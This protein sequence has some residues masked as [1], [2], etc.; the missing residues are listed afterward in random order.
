MEWMTSVGE[1]IGGINCLLENLGFN[2]DNLWNVE[3]WV[4]G[5]FA[6][7][8]FLGPLRQFVRQI[9][10]THYSELDKIYMDILEMSLDR[11]Y[12]RDKE[13]IERFVEYLKNQVDPDSQQISTNLAPVRQPGYEGFRQKTAKE[14][15]RE[16]VAHFLLGNEM[17]SLA[18][19]W[20]IPRPLCQSMKI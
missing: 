12:L 19:H 20:R 1:F 13:Q 17:V 7:F 15:L 8:V 18:C 14:R 5:F 11:T 6:I 2:P 4:A 16:S 3:R 9:R 10:S